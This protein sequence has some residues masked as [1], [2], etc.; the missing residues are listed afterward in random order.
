MAQIVAGRA[1]ARRAMGRDHAR[2]VAHTAGFNV[3]MML[4][5]SV[6]GLFLARVLGP[7]RRGD[8]VTILLWPAMIGSAASVGITQSTCYWVSRRPGHARSIISTAALAA[9]AMGL[10]VTLLGPWI[11]A[12]IGRSAEV[13]RDLAVVLALTPV[14]IAG[15]VWMATLQSAAISQWNWA[16][17]TQPVLYLIGVV[18]LWAF[19]ILSLD[20]VV[21]VFAAALVVQTSVSVLMVRRTVGRH[22]R[23]S[24]SL[25]GPL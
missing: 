23:P 12:L 6:G 8:L 20:G 4:A 18:C 14:F 5:G 2:A 24:L 1:A 3:A 21:A 11:A 25:V 17:V 19:G 15:G 13:R 9:V 16:R 7:T 10:T 22:S